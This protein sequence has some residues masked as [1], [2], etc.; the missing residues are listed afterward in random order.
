MTAIKKT[1]LQ[2]IQDI[3]SDTD[4]EPINSISDSLEGEQIATIIEHTFYDMVALRDIPEHEELIKLVPLSDN[5]YPTHF[6]YPENVKNVTKVWYDHSDDDTKEYEEVLWCDPEQFLRRTDGR[7]SDF[8]NVTEIVS[9]TNLRILSNRQPSFYT[10][11]DDYY[12]IMDSFKSTV[13]DTLRESKVRAM[14][15]K[16]PEFNRFDDDYIPD[17]DLSHFP[18]LV[19]ESRA[20]AMDFFKGG[21]TQKA[22]QASRRAKNYVQNE[23]HRT[24]RPNDR[25]R[26]GRHG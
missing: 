19:S 7:Q 11:F 23:L 25:N 20:R 16:V 10:S 17:I 24:V 21:V 4:G 12:I 1:L 9:G 5:L 8:Q 3:L 13:D 22:E 18:L 6:Y 14:G 2:I 15:T 26:Y